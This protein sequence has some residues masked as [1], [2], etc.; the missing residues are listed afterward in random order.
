MKIQAVSDPINLNFT[1]EFWK[2]FKGPANDRSP[3]IVFGARMKLNVFPIFLCLQTC[4]QKISLHW[5]RH[6]VSRC[7]CHAHRRIPINGRI[8]IPNPSVSIAVDFSRLHLGNVSNSIFALIG[9]D[10][11]TIEGAIEQLDMDLARLTFGRN[12]VR[13]SGSSEVYPMH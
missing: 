11:G 10:Y 2:A 3:R 7:R 13:P 1:M 9:D 5:L 6:G 4:R 12:L 8:P